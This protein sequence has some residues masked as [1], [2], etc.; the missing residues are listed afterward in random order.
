MAWFCLVIDRSRARHTRMKS[1]SMKSG[2]AFMLHFDFVSLPCACAEPRMRTY[3]RIILRGLCSADD[4]ARHGRRVSQLEWS[5]GLRDE[6]RI[7][8]RRPKALFSWSD[9]APHNLLF[10]PIAYYSILFVFS[11]N[12]LIIGYLGLKHSSRKVQPNRAISF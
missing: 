10:S 12:C 8:S 3:G 9:S 2:G 7:K 5:G 6:R 4:H 11:N 1:M